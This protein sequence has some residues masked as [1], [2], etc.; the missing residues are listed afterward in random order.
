MKTFVKI[1]WAIGGFLLVLCGCMA[2]F[3]PFSGV[4]TFEIAVGIGLIVS[5]LL[6]VITYAVTR[7]VLL[8]AGWVLADGLL[9]VVL[10]AILLIAMTYS[11]LVTAEF[12]AVIS[13]VFAVIVGIWLI[14]TAI[15]QITRAVDLHKLGAKGWGW[16]LCFGIIGL[17][18]ALC[19][20]CRPVVTMMGAM[21]F[22]LGISLIVGGVSLIAR[23]FSRDIEYYD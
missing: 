16:G 3:N 2:F 13:V 9:S 14:S 20:F 4:V 19:L 18:C 5:G 23:C 7:K 17:L 12:A 10:G 8:G 15:T 21:S 22:V 6:S 11:D 1:M